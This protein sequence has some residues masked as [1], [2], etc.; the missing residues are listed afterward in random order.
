MEKLYSKKVVS[1]YKNP[2]NMGRMNDPDG[3][4]FI[5]GL[6]GDIMEIYLLIE[7]ETI[8][9]IYFHTEGC[10]VTLACGSML[11]ELVMGKTIQEA[12]KISP[13][14]VMNALDGLP[15]DGIHCAILAVNTMHKAIADYL[16]KTE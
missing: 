2:V 1:Y 4:A 14:D 3:G 7:G 10:G 6:C 12:L 11:T 8:Y 16:L 15:R 5:K 9:K 13:Y